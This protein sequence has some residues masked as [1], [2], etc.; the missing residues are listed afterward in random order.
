[1][2]TVQLSDELEKQFE[3]LSIKSGKNKEWCAREAILDYLQDME[4][5]FIAEE[6]MMH[7]IP[8]AATTL[9]DLEKEL[10]LA[11]QV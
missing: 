7:F 8:D 5:Y 1:M 10:G 4:H 9:E 2:I 11:D 6:R 3:R